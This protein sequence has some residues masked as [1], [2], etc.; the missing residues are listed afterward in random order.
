M[1]FFHSAKFLKAKRELNLLLVLHQY[2][3]PEKRL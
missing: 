1:L 3:P 2:I